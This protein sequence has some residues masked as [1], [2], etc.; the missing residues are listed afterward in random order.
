MIDRDFAI[1]LIAGCGFWFMIWFVPN[2]TIP[3]YD[4]LFVEKTPEIKQALPIEA[5]RTHEPEYKWVEYARNQDTI[6]LYRVP[7]AV[8]IVA[9]STTHGTGKLIIQYSYK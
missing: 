3:I 8:K 6:Y 4:H 5:V 1:G 2:V 9:D 7:V